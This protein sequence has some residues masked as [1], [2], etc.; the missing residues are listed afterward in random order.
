MALNLVGATGSFCPFSASA[1]VLFDL[2]RHDNRLWAAYNSTLQ[3]FCFFFSSHDNDILQ[4]SSA[5]AIVSLD[6]RILQSQ[7]AFAEYHDLL[8]ALEQRLLCSENSEEK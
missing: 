1:Q 7:P 6:M 5:D 2:F 8:Q 4:Y 3:V